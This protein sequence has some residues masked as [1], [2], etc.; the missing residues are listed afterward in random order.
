M[1]PSPAPAPAATA[2]DAAVTT[3][4]AEHAPTI[5]VLGA[6]HEICLATDGNTVTVTATS[7]LNADEFES[8]LSAEQIAT[9]VPPGFAESAASV[10]GFKEFLQDAYGQ[11][12]GTVA[13]PEVAGAAPELTCA[14]YEATSVDP[15]RRARAL[16]E[17]KQ[18]ER[19]FVT[20]IT[21]PVPGRY[22]SDLRIQLSL[23]LKAQ[24]SVTGL[25]QDRQQTDICSVL[26]GLQ[27]QLQALQRE[28]SARTAWEDVQI[29]DEAPFDVRYEYCVEV[30]TH[31]SCRGNPGDPTCRS[32]RGRSVAAKIAA[33]KKA[34]LEAAK[35]EAAAAGGAGPM[36]G[37]HP[38]VQYPNGYHAQ[39]AE[40]LAKCNHS[41]ELMLLHAVMVR[42]SMLGFT[43][44]FSAH[45]QQ[46]ARQLLLADRT[47]LHQP[48]GQLSNELL[49]NLGNTRD[50][51]TD[52][53]MDAIK[54]W[55]AN[56]ADCINVPKACGHMLVRKIMRRRVTS[57]G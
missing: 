40:T 29:Y 34:E 48:Q 10:A 43:S 46:P 25:E 14:S 6:E 19:S 57:E 52:F 27:E 3:I 33:R 24:A 56:G 4:Q 42:P 49:G 35:L 36:C 38:A 45:W 15:V 16:T 13:V 37:P 47:L 44:R 26:Q 39:H 5:F 9:L 41:E 50:L 11:E 20:N 7:L 32:P 1:L 55:L 8:I 28:Q 22:A 17:T 51:D 31:R 12:A 18:L 54:G 30:C 2:Q 23:P 53:N 21:I